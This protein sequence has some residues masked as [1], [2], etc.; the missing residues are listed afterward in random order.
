MT[1][2]LVQPNPY[3]LQQEI[4]RF[5]EVIRQRSDCDRGR[6][7]RARLRYTRSW[8]LAVSRDWA[9]ADGEYA[10]ALYNASEMGL[11]FIT[12]RPVNVGQTL[13]IRLFW[14]DDNSPR[15]PAVVRHV[16]PFHARYIVGCEF[17]FVAPP[18]RNVFGS[19]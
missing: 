12:S 8:P 16:T 11:A 19:R 10:V 1:T 7:Q 18:N 17:T 14:Y 5:I 15:V 2:T 13:Y 9:S 3:T 4:T 6:R